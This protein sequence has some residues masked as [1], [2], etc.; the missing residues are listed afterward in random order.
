MSVIDMY[1]RELLKVNSHEADVSQ[2]TA[3]IYFLRVF[4]KDREY[5]CKFVKK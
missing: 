3:G 1:G 4:G 2:L 5:V